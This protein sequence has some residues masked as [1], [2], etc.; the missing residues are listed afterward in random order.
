MRAGARELFARAQIRARR[1]K[2][3]LA[4]ADVLH[5]RGAASGLPFFT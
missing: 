3:V 2:R 1:R 4:V 5:D